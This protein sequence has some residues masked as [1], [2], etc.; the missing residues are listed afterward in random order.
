[1]GVGSSGGGWVVGDQYVNSVNSFGYAFLPDILFGTY[2][3]DAAAQV[4]DRAAERL[5]SPGR[6][7]FLRTRSQPRTRSRASTLARSVAGPAAHAVG[8]RRRARRGVAAG[9]AV[10]VVG[11][12][13]RR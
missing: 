13:A 1:M 7:L 9:A 5:S 12:R 10:E 2:F 3:G 4:Y 6:Q 11:R 8:A